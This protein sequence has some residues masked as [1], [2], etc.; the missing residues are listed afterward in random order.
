[1]K[2]Y[3]IFGMA[4]ITLLFL[5]VIYGGTFNLDSNSIVFIVAN[6][7]FSFIF[8]ALIFFSSW[9]I[10]YK[11]KVSE[12]KSLLKFYKEVLINVVL[13]YFLC[14]IPYIIYK[15]GINNLSFTELMKILVE[16]NMLKQFIY[17]KILMHLLIIYPLVE[18][19]TI[20]NSKIT[21]ITSLILSM[22]FSLFNLDKY[23]YTNVF[24]YLIYLALGI[25]FS[26]NGDDITYFLRNKHRKLGIDIVFSGLL[27]FI[28]SFKLYNF[29]YP[30]PEILYNISVILIMVYS[31][32]KTKVYFYNNKKYLSDNII[33]N[34]PIIIISIFLLAQIIFELIQKLLKYTEGK[35]EAQLIIV[36]IFFVIYLL[37]IRRINKKYGIKNEDI[38]G[39][40]DHK[41]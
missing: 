40:I 34:P 35:E 26:H 30:I 29:F 31:F 3:K 37:N 11:R 23:I 38:Y 5:L 25:S 20:K 14:M 18:Y 17:L 4:M 19:F 36:V 22:I 6:F 12:D 2:P 15:Y 13:P 9:L 10:S 21:V 7:I 41:K 39:R 28:T 8:P 32:Y 27:V 16:G 24:N 33:F 1:M